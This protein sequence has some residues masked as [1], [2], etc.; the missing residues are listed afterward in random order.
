MVT[1]NL[2]LETVIPFSEYWKR[3]MHLSEVCNTKK[4]GNGLVLLF[5]DDDN[6]NYYFEKIVHCCN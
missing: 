5:N 4:K 3:N 6:N 1:L 2:Y